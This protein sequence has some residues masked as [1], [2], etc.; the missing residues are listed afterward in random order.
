MSQVRRSEYLLQSPE[1]GLLHLVRSA[2]L[3]FAVCGCFE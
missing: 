3:G 2:G 1:T